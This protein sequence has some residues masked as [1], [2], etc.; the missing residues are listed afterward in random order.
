[1]TDLA[2]WGHWSIR[3]IALSYLPL[4]EMRAV[5]AGIGGGALCC[6]GGFFRE[7]PQVCIMASIRTCIWT[8]IGNAV[9]IGSRIGVGAKKC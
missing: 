4:H 5:L 7:T 3:H 1:M 6:R 9:S 2:V 8:A